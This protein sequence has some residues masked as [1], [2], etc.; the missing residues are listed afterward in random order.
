MEPLRREG[1]L[2]AATQKRWDADSILARTQRAETRTIKT[3]NHWSAISKSRIGRG[4]TTKFSRF[5]VLI[6]FETDR[7]IVSAGMLPV[8]L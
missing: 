7:D 5:H 1:G 3:N 2:N 8:L 6:G 4:V